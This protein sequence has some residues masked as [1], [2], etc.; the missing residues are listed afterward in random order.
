MSFLYIIHKTHYKKLYKPHIEQLA[1]ASK[2]S[3]VKRVR[4]LKEEISR[5]KTLSNY[6]NINNQIKKI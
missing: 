5:T 3:K 6:S 2:M 4:K 1:S